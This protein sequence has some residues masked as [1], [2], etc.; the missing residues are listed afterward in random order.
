[1][2]KPLNILICDDHH[3]FSSGLELML[4]RSSLACQVTVTNSSADCKNHL[5]ANHFELFICD[6]NIDTS[7]GFEIINE[8]K[9][10]LS[11][12]KIIL[13]SGY[14]ELFLIQKAQKY[15]CHAY[16]KKNT[17]IDDLITV[18][19]QEKSSQ[20]ICL[21]Q[22]SIRDENLTRIE[23]S[24]L[25]KIKLSQ[26]EKKIILLIVEGKKSI[27]ISALLFI[28]KNTV[29]THRR[30]IYRKLGLKSMAALITFA[31]ENTVTS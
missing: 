17:K 19:Q 8:M 23:N 13:L 27:E 12:T 14:Q 5:R 7:D 20:L 6:I 24:S 4:T 16:L 25:H 11:D 29:D 2:K 9:S 26:Q 15:G 21:G 30:N 1:M 18:I 31:N 10:L 3:L 28:S 22:K